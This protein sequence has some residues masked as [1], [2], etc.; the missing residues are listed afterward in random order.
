MKDLAG[1]KFG[2]WKVVKYVGNVPGIKTKRPSKRYL[3]RCECGTIRLVLRSTLLS[4]LPGSC[5]CS[6]VGLCSHGFSG[7]PTYSSW[8]AMMNRC[9][10]KDDVSYCYYGGR[11]ITVCKRWQKFENFLKDMGIRPVGRSIGR[12]DNEKGYSK[13]NCKWSTVEE[14]SNNRR[15]SVFF[16][17]AG[18]RLTVSQWSKLLGLS[19]DATKGKFLSGWKPNRADLIGRK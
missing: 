10:R 9:F 5:G 1:R 18:R 15:N 14:Q 2:R 7:S 6:R 4:L 8:S 16:S 12:M 19:Y 3:C 17:A 11:G 13:N